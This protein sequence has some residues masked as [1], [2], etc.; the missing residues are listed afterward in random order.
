MGGWVEGRK[1]PG[2]AQAP[3]GSPGPGTPAKQCPCPAPCPFYFPGVAWDAA[4]GPPPPPSP[5]GALSPLPEPHPSVCRSGRRWRGVGSSARSPVSA[6][7]RTSAPRGMPRRCRQSPSRAGRPLAGPGRPYRSE[8]GRSYCQTGWSRPPR[9]EATGGEGASL[10]EN[11][12]VGARAQQPSRFSARKPLVGSVLGFSGA[13][14]GP[15]S[16]ISTLGWS[17]CTWCR[18]LTGRRRELRGGVCGGTGEWSLALAGSACVWGAPGR[19]GGQ[20]LAPWTWQLS[21]GEPG[22]RPALPLARLPGEE[23]CSADAP[24]W[25]P[26]ARVPLAAQE[27]SPRRVARCAVLG[28]RQPLEPQ[29]PAGE[30]VATCGGFAGAPSDG[31]RPC[32]HPIQRRGLCQLRGGWDAVQQLDSVGGRTDPNSALA[33]VCPEAQEQT[34]PPKSLR[35]RGRRFLPALAGVKSGCPNRRSAPRPRGQGEPPAEAAGEGQAAP[36]PGTCPSPVPFPKPFPARLKWSERLSPS[37]GSRQWSC[38]GSTN[39]QCLLA[40]A[41]PGELFAVTSNFLPPK[42]TLSFHLCTSTSSLLPTPH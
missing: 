4:G 19:R 2:A 22:R 24:P 25:A 3:R 10:K 23:A 21:G 11:A 32:R 42:K 39:R 28:P 13:R 35:E 15:G 9:Y 14:A 34:G 18:D 20:N 26:V 36:P 37:L 7:S 31:E 17:W 29:V 8:G 12:A 1:L 38:Q 6:A 40:F 27:L 5:L 30:R 33:A 16:P 41:Y